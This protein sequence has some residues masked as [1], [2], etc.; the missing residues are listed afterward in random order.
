MIHIASVLPLF[1]TYS[2]S[3][4]NMFRNLKD[5]NIC[6]LSNDHQEPLQIETALFFPFRLYQITCSKSIYE[7][8]KY[9][10]QSNLFCLIVIGFQKRMCTWIISNSNIFQLFPLHFFQVSN[11]RYILVNCPSYSLSLFILK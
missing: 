11:D 4:W 3:R 8:K 5:E 2:H 9:H 10:M 1:S 7:S 6:L